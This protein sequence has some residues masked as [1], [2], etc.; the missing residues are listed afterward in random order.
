MKP[1]VKQ[2]DS[3]KS[4]VLDSRATLQSKDQIQEP[5]ELRT[6]VYTPGSQLEIPEFCVLNVVQTSKTTT[7]SS[8]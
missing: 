8:R 2:K 3:E 5:A 4:R 1:R 6:L 7:Q